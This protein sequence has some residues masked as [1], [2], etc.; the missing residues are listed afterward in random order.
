MVDWSATYSVAFMQISRAPCG[1]QAA[2][3]ISIRVILLFGQL[4]DTTPFTPKQA[5]PLRTRD[6][7]SELHSQSYFQF[8]SSSFVA[9]FLN[10][11]RLQYRHTAPPPPA[12]QLAP[13]QSD[14]ASFSHLHRG[15]VDCLSHRPSSLTTGPTPIPNSFDAAR[16]VF[17]PDSTAPR[18]VGRDVFAQHGNKY[19]Y[20]PAAPR[21]QNSSPLPSSAHSLI[22]RERAAV[23][24]PGAA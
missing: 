19:Q 18:I 24:T 3:G 15:N 1:K 5:R 9:R 6:A 14:T 17:A 16:L 13:L 11:Q 8:R 12:P 22:L 4:A 21:C 23:A 20:V 10:S 2:G 7:L